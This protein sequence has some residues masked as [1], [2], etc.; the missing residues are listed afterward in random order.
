V[1][2]R[3][4]YLLLRL[5]AEFGA[6][7]VGLWTLISADLTLQDLASMIGA[8]RVTVS[9]TLA[10]LGRDDIV[11]TGRKEVRVHIESAREELERR[12]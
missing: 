10:A 12:V 11:R 2:S 1:R 6:E 5:A 9:A 4:L 8:T 7:Q 3:I